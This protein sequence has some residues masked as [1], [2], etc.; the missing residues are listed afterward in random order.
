ML[1]HWIGLTGEGEWLQAQVEPPQGPSQWQDWSFSW[2]AAEPGRHSFRA[3]ATDAAGNVQ[4]D[5]APWNRLGYGNNA[6]EITYVDLRWSTS[7]RSG[8]TGVIIPTV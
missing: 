5:A 2:N 6:I 7:A 4:P 3:R 1:I 8:R